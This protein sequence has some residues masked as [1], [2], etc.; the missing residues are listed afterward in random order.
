MTGN[1]I[2]AASMAQ[3]PP[4]R[5]GQIMA[6]MQ[7]RSGKTDS[8]VLKKCVTAEDLKNPGAFNHHDDKS[9]KKTVIAETATQ[10]KYSVVCTGENPST[11]TA[12]FSVDSP[13]S[14]H[15]IIDMTPNSGQA[16]IHVE[17]TGRWLGD[18]CT[19]K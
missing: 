17:E 11:G 4:E 9:C 5:R 16:K 8:H 18:S 2:P 3:I 10:Q 19:A 7:A 1:P 6:A 15:G 14:I 13:T 12:N